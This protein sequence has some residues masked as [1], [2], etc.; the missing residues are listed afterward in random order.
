MYCF[1]YLRGSCTSKYWELILR[2]EPK[3]FTPSRAF[4]DY[5]KARQVETFYLFLFAV[6][7]IWFQL[8]MVKHLGCKVGTS[9]SAAFLTHK[10]GE[11]LVPQRAVAPQCALKWP[12]YDQSQ[13]FGP[14]QL[15]TVPDW[16]LFNNLN[17]SKYRLIFCVSPNGISKYPDHRFYSRRDLYVLSKTGSDLSRCSTSPPYEWTKRRIKLH[18]FLSKKPECP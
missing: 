1:T 9:L 18:L 11:G 3:I 6:F 2:V 10:R 4:D 17:Q 5:K 15:L 8:V 7:R 16:I 13:R 12:D 14:P